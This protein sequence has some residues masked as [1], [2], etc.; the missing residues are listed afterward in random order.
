M[1]SCIV[2][3]SALLPGGVT[4]LDMLWR[5]SAS[6]QCVVGEVPVSRWNE[7]EGV[8]STPAEVVQRLRHGGFLY[9]AELFDNRFFSISGAGF[10]RAGRAAM[11]IRVYGVK[12]GR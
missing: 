6:G 8:A 11:D 5:M 10:G 3:S 1:P 4:S 9:Q 2:G 7:P 12:A